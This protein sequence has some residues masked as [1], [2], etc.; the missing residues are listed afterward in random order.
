MV[1]GLA[2]YGKSFK[3]IGF[4]KLQTGMLKNKSWRTVQYLPVRYLLIC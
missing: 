4:W 2:V 3:I 1:L